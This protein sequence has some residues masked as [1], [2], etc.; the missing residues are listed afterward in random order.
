MQQEANDMH[1]SNELHLQSTYQL[2]KGKAGRTV[3]KGDLTRSAPRTS[4]RT[5]C[6]KSRGNYDLYYLRS[7]TASEFR[8]GG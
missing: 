7:L 2:V 4:A 6:L 3:R 5:R 1:A 8:K